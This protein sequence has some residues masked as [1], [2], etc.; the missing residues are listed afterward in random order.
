LGFIAVASEDKASGSP[1]TLYFNAVAD[2]ST[3]QGFNNWYYMYNYDA[4]MTYGPNW[5]ESDSWHDPEGCCAIAGAWMHPGCGGCDA[6]IATRKW[7][8]PASGQ[9]HVYGNAHKMDVGGNGVYAGISHDST[10]LWS[11]YIGGYDSVGYDFDITL[12][13]AQGDAI[14]FTVSSNCSNFH[15]STSFD[16]TIALTVS[17]PTPVPTPTATQTRTPTVTVTITPTSTKTAT[18]TVT[19][20]GSLTPTPTRTLS[21]PPPATVTVTPTPSKT[22]TATPSTHTPTPTNTPCPGGIC[23]GSLVRIGSKTL[24]P[25]ESG[26]VS[27]EALGMPSPGLGAFTIDVSYDPNIVHPVACD[28]DPD[29]EFDIEICNMAYGPG[30]VRCTGISITGIEGDVVLCD[31]TF[32]AD[33]ASGTQSALTL[34][35]DELADALGQPVPVTTEDGTI[36]VGVLGDASGDGRTTMV[37][38]MLI[39][40]CIAGLIDCDSI[41]QEMGDVNCSGSATMVDAMLIAQKVAGLIDEFSCV[42]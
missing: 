24:P 26:T 6:D 32:Q 17:M 4:P 21:P 37:D 36:T 39:A 23:P 20:T 29:D 34:S 5:W 16:A 9:A 2:F 31:I 40:Q 10:S 30:V 11:T 42:P 38:A 28:A 1:E 41:N 33:G 18:P 22:A 19:P 14:Y 35:V 25:G 3:V 12:E 7:V 15:D 13:V 27:L 8:S